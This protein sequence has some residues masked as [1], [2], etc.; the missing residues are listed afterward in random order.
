[1]IRAAPTDEF[2]DVGNAG[3][4]YTHTYFP[5]TADPTQ[6]TLVTAAAAGH[7]SAID[8]PL[9]IGAPSAI[10]G[11]LLQ[12]NGAPAG[13]AEVVRTGRRLRIRSSTLQADVDRTTAA[14]DGS[15]AF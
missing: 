7:V 9:V 1:M 12:S 3:D 11:R 15:F 13:A 4:A 6:A 10:A 2:V 14:D 8:F 5:G